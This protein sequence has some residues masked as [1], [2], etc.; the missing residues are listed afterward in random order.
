MNVINVNIAKRKQNNNS[1]NTLKTIV[2]I[3]S[4]I[5]F[6]L[7]VLVLG[8]NHFTHFHNI[9]LQSHIPCVIDFVGLLSYVP[10]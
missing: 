10:S 9:I 2:L 4:Y 3:V 7:V 8:F 1:S 5:S 6:L